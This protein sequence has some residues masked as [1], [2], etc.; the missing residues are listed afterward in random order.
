MRGMAWVMW[1]EQRGDRMHAAIDA[2]RTQRNARQ[3]APIH[4]P[5][6]PACSCVIRGCVPKKLLVYGS[7]VRWHRIVFKEPPVDQ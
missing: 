5:P 4:P 1:Y 6:A 3:L 2:T 7:Q